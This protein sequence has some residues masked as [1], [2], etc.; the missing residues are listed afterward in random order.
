MGNCITCNC[1]TD[2]FRC[3][4]RIDEEG[5]RHND[6]QC[7]KC[8]MIKVNKERKIYKKRFE[9][10]ILPYLIK[11]NFRVVVNRDGDTEEIFKVKEYD[12]L[13]CVDI[14]RKRMKSKGYYENWIDI[15]SK[16]YKGINFE[17]VDYLCFALPKE[18]SG[19]WVSYSFK[20]VG[21]CK[22]KLRMTDM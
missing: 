18:D 5:F 7:E 1:D 12:F 11:N 15:H 19:S 22:S 21:D 20:L 16:S 8:V 9:K 6:Y 17:M 2:D 4:V 3:N 13:K 10:I 14:I